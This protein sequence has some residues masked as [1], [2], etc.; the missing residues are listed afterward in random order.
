MC[1]C[2]GQ[3]LCRNGGGRGD[4]EATGSDNLEVVQQQQCSGSS[5]AAAVRRRQC[6]GG[7]AAVAVRRRQCSDGRVSVANDD[8]SKHKTVIVCDRQ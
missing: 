4:G 2:T 8:S 7:S 3:A 6:G 1:G 5:A